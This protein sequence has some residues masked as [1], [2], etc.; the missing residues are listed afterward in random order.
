M[1]S[2]LAFPTRV[3]NKKRTFQ[4]GSLCFAQVES[5]QLGTSFVIVS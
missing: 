5:W 2:E 1:C 4:I 3:C